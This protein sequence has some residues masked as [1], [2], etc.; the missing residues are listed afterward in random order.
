LHLAKTGVS[1]VLINAALTGLKFFF[2]V[3]VER[4]DAIARTSPVRV[5]CKL[6]VVL[7]R[8][9]AARL[10]ACAGKA[11]YRAALSV[12]Y[13]AGLRDNSVR[14]AISRIDCLSRKC[15]RLILPTMNRVITSV[16]HR[17][18]RSRLG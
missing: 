11:K 15:I 9:E 7:S 8:E 1:P 2:E 18:K 13:G 16:P 10:I 6:P 4:A 14:R 3:T 5:P 12:A 17:A